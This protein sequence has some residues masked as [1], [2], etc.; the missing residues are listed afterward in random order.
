L[1]SDNES[2]KIVA[3]S[4]MQIDPNNPNKFSEVSMMPYYNIE[5]KFQGNLPNNL[6]W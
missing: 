4:D 3:M 1:A 5:K 2:F 6:A